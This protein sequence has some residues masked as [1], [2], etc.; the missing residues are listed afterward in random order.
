MSEQEE[1]IGE[2][3]K[4]GEFFDCS[5]LMESWKCS[6]C[7]IEVTASEPYYSINLWHYCPNCGD[8][9]R[10]VKHEK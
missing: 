8:K 6:S 2:W 3:I 5:F 4:T 7:W 9:K 1:P 10:A